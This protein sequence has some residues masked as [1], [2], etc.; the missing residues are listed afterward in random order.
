MN[1]I[2]F[3]LCLNNFSLI[4]VNDSSEYA[5]YLL[6]L[7]NMGGGVSLIENMQEVMVSTILI[8]RAISAVSFPGMYR[9]YDFHSA[10]F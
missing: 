3:D 10:R 1:P 5:E 9:I 6:I 8:G 7:T 2:I 4:S